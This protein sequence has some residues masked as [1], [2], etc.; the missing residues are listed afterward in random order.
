[1][2]IGIVYISYGRAEA[3][4]VVKSIESLRSIGDNFS[5][6]PV[7]SYQID[8]SYYDDKLNLLSCPIFLS[9]MD[10]NQ[11]LQYEVIR[12]KLIG[13]AICIHTNPFDKFLL[14]DPSARFT[15][16]AMFL[17]ENRCDG[18]LATKLSVI[19]DVIGRRLRHLLNDNDI[20]FDDSLILPNTL[21][22]VISNKINTSISRYLIDSYT[23]I[24]RNRF[25]N[26]MI[27]ESILLAIGCKSLKYQ[28]S[29]IKKMNIIDQ[30]NLSAPVLSEQQDKH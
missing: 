2:N 29:F 21:A 22:M 19:S 5:K 25:Y 13:R 30:V 24:N 9:H 8:K 7:I 11:N 10:I 6:L 15:S 28:M 14:L 3:R 20:N 23:K 26:S 27:L 1:M 16:S 12:A 17:F 18:V 4:N